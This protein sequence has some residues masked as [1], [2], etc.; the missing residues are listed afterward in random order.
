MEL[1]DRNKVNLVQY[2]LTVSGASSWT[3]V[4]AVGIPYQTLDGAWRLKFNLYGTQSSSGSNTLTIAGVTFHAAYNQATH[5]SHMMNASYYHSE[6]IKNT[7]TVSFS[8]QATSE[9]AISGDVELALKPAWI[10]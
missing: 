10:E 5:F 7:S 8:G 2:N 6:T 3:T 9:A 1:I 4:R